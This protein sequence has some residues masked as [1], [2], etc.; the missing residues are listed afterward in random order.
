MYEGGCIVLSGVLFVAILS[1]FVGKVSTRLMQGRARD[2][3]ARVMG[4]FS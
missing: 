3:I 1:G 2:Q 4:S